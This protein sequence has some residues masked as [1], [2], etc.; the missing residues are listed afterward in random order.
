MTANGWDNEEAAAALVA[1]QLGTTSF[2]RRD[3]PGAPAGTHDFDL[4]VGSKTIAL[5]VTSS[6]DEETTKLWK[7]VD[8]QEWEEPTLTRSW[9]L[10]LTP[11]THVKTLRSGVAL[12][13]HLLESVGIWKFDESRPPRTWP[14]EA[15]LALD[16][17][18]KLGVRRGHSQIDPP[19]RIVIGVNG[20][21]GWGDRDDLN[22]AMERS[23]AEIIEKLRRAT[24]EARHLFVWLDWT[25]FE[26]QAA[27]HFILDLG[28]FPNVP[29]TMP[30]GL[31]EVWTAPRALADGRERPLLRASKSGWQLVT[32]GVG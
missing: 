11:G 24:A 23:I 8:K 12:H 16:T 22:R 1:E 2:V 9:G 13:L 5:E 31:D 14:P 29:P 25:D 27:M 4:Q 26:A 28:I 15:L 20:P 3:V 19:T 6:T 18:R 32:G 7:S 10:V 17:L 30:D 21:G